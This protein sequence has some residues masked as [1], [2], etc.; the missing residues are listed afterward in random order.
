MKNYLINSKLLDK[1]IKLFLRIFYS[2][3]SGASGIKVLLSV[4]FTQKIL[5]INRFVPWPVHFTSRIINAKN[6]K[7]GR[8][9][10]PG[11][12]QSCYIQAKNGIII[13]NNLRMGPGVGLVSANHDLN[14]YD[15]WLDECPIYIGDN[16]VIATNSLVSKEI[17]SN[18]IARGI[19]CKFIKAK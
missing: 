12:S 4:F 2:K 5:G 15:K 13:G 9:S 1:L 16:V 10:F 17:L 18:V 3:I 7:L 11:W 19:P 14:N 6:V 8:R